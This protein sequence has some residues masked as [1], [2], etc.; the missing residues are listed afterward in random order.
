M[1]TSTTV[2]V[3]HLDK[4]QSKQISKLV[5][6]SQSKPISVGLH[7]EFKD[8]EDF[9]LQIEEQHKKFISFF[10]F[11]PSHVDIHKFKSVQESAQFISDFCIKNN[12]PARNHGFTEDIL[13]PEVYFNGSLNDLNAIEHFL[14]S[15]EDGKT[16]EILFHPGKYDPDS[17]SSYNK[18]REQDVEKIMALEPLLK[19][20]GIN[21]VNFKHLSEG[22]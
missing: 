7:V 21:L 5:L 6:L 3:N 18:E 9:S 4:S 2:M 22:N 17:K 16:Y 10:G 12:L 14:A 19:E 13:T 8:N 20:H 11:E 1:I 15:M